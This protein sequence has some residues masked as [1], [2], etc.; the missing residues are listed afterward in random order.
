LNLS[1]S[2][3]F[4][5]QG[6]QLILDYR[7]AIFWKERKALLLSDIHLGKAGHF[8]KAGIAIPEEVHREDYRKLDSLIA[9][10]KPID[11]IILGDIFHSDWNLGWEYFLQWL[12]KHPHVHFHLV[13]GNHDI[14]YREQYR[15]ANFHLST[16]QLVMEPFVLSHEI[17]PSADWPHLYQISGHLHPSVR[18]NGKGR[19]AMTLACFYF[20]EK[21]A[22]LPAFGSFTGKAILKPSKACSIFV[23]TGQHVIAL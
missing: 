4:Q 18:L 23:L 12:A 19:Q 22:I 7:K 6:Q 10:Y 16:E 2:L 21:A 1:S 3:P 9:D 17:Q 11:L 5:L 13:P 20:E 8:R 14:L 15:A